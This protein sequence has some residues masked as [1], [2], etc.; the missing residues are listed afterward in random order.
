MPLHGELGQE[1]THYVPRESYR[2]R[3]ALFF[4]DSEGIAADLQWLRYGVTELLTQDL[5]QNPFLLA[6]T[7]FSAG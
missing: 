6:Q 1:E 3:I 4:W 2:R 7:Y 5:Q